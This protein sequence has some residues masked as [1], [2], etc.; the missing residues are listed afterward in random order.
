LVTEALDLLSPAVKD[1]YSRA[2]SLQEA[3]NVIPSSSFI[4]WT[5]ALEYHLSRGDISARQV[6]EFVDDELTTD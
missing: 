5:R 4:P 3:I 6:Q 2:E 1:A